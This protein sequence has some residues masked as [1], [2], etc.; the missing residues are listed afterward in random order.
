MVLDLKWIWH[1]ILPGWFTDSVI[2]R[3]AQQTGSE[4][5]RLAILL[6][7][8]EARLEQICHRHR[9]PQKLE[10]IVDVTHDVLLVQSFSMIIKYCI[11]PLISFASFGL[12]LRHINPLRQDRRVNL[13]SRSYMT[14]YC[15]WFTLY[16]L[17]MAQPWRH[18]QAEQRTETT[19][20][21][22]RL[23]RRRQ[24]RHE[25]HHQRHRE[26]RA[27]ISDVVMKIVTSLT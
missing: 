8:T 14:S 22:R 6:D 1:N 15:V 24:I 20:T 10:N 13:Y 11:V 5:K 25:R 23:W 9:Q 19:A 3:I 17:G 18:P 27:I 7:F 26:H 12:L 2:V 16:V 4:Y 21:N